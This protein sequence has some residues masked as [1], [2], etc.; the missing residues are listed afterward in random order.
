M[1][2]SEL[3]EGAIFRFTLDESSN[4]KYFIKTSK[5]CD[6]SGN[7]FVDDDGV[8][9][10]EVELT[11]VQKVS[12][13]AKAMGYDYQVELSDDDKPDKVVLLF[14][15]ERYWPLTNEFQAMELAKKFYMT[16][17]F[18]DNSAVVE[19]PVDGTMDQTKT[20]SNETINHAIVD[21]VIKY[22]LL[23]GTSV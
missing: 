4:P 15:G 13:C 16:L 20:F 21:A 6:L 1:K 3:K 22:Q 11:L 2:Y 7:G 14:T 12:F 10:T 19:H 18:F 8:N 17:S 5:G 9:F 23:L